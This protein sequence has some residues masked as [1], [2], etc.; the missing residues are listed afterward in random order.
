MT[1]KLSPLVNIGVIVPNAEEAYQ[2]LFNLFGAQ[3]VQEELTNFLNGDLAKVIHVGLGDVILQF[4]E[5]IA[6]EGAWYNHLIK[7]GPGV[8]NLRFIVENIK[9]VIE[10]ME[11]QG[12]IDPLFTFDL[13]WEKLIASD[14]TNPNGKTI[15]T[16]DTMEKIGFHLCLSEKPGQNELIFPQTQYVT[17]FDNLIGDASTMLHIELVTPNA[18]KTYEFLQKVFGSEK[19]EIEF[20]G[21]LD[22]DFMRI[23]HVNLSNVVLQ[24][25]QPIAKTG[26]WYELLQKNGAYVHNLNFLVDDIKETVRKFKKEEIPRIFK[27]RLAPN[28]PPYYM[29][30]TIN[31][32]GF[33]LEHG[34]M[35]TGEEFDFFSKWVFTN[36]K[37]D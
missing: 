35:P 2:L 37:K 29:M 5:P 14:F 13:E 32:L 20:A 4:I 23:I 19:V 11:K 16:M 34:Q 31:K 21:I 24:Y 9:E 28:S 33:H 7:E 36:L 3:K 6:K 22:S 15:Y 27:N 25:C 17:G 12:G 8:Y 1:V 26:T 10:E 30:N 18:E